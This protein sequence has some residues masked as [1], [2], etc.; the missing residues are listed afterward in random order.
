MNIPVEFEYPGRMP[1]IDRDPYRT[2]HVYRLMCYCFDF[3]SLKPNQPWY[4]ISSETIYDA[5]KHINNAYDC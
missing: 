5:V 2:L 1:I 4:S 3:N